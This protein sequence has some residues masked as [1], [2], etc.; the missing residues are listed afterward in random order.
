MRKAF[1]LDLFVKQA[2]GTGVWDSSLR[3]SLPEIS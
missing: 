3:L 1:S 2:R